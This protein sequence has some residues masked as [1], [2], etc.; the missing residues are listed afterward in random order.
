MT[1]KI[2]KEAQSLLQKRYFSDTNLKSISAYYH[3]LNKKFKEDDLKNVSTCQLIALELKK[4]LKEKHDIDADYLFI[5][6]NPLTINFEYNKLMFNYEYLKLVK[7]RWFEKAE[8]F[9]EKNTV[10]FERYKKQRYTHAMLE[11][12]IGKEKYVIDPTCGIVY[13]TGKEDL[14]RGI[15]VYESLLANN[16]CDFLMKSI[17]RGQYTNIYSTIKYWRNVY[18]ISYNIG[19][20]LPIL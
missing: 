15:G 6:N 17:Q 20:G 14:I 7:Q 9:V 13:E 3:Y 10:L 4:I 18:H 16:Q 1:S 19:G 8:D 5:Y 12:L 11:V 2:I